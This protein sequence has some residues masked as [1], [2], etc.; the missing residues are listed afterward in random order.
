[1]YKEYF[2]LK[3]NPFTINSDPRY[4]HYTRHT[5]DALNGLKHGIEARKG[6]ILLTGEVGTGKTTLLNKLLESL[7]EQSVATAFIFNPRLSAVQL[8]DYMVADFGIACKSRAKSQVLFKLHRWLLDRYQ[9]GEPT[10]LVVDEAQNLSRH[11]L[12]EIRLLTNLETSTDK[13][14]Q[15]VLAGQPE[16]EQSLDQ[17]ELRQ[18]RQRIAV[19][20]K[21]LPLT[22]EETCG[23]ISERLRIAGCNGE[24]IFTPMAI[25]AVHRHARG[26]PR[27]TNLISEHALIKAFAQRQKPVPAEIVDDVTREFSL[28]ERDLP[29]QPPPPRRSD[30]NG[31]GRRHIERSRARW[32]DASSRQRPDEQPNNQTP[33]GMTPNMV[34]LFVYGCDPDGTPFYEEAQ[35]IATS[36]RGGLISMKTPVRPGQRLLLTNKENE[37]SQECLIEFLG[38]RLRRGVDVAFEFPASAPD[39]WG[40]GE[41]KNPTSE[42]ACA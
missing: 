33:F 2:G 7:H 25:E 21:T 32:A 34:Q 38:A 10:V 14:L 8:F 18:L 39:F 28:N 9:A 11:A 16:L 41:Q 23:Y 27:V 29:A 30:N 15:I 12:E 40:A 20:A 36:N 17:R 31:R 4:L 37:C 5:Q 22:P 3:E 24:E 1:V 13:L 6:F 42:Q 26:I 19:R 35:T